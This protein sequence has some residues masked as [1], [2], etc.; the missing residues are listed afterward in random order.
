MDHL[1]SHLSKS[2]KFG[3]I[4]KRLIEFPLQTCPTSG[5]DDDV[6][7]LRWLDLICVL[8]EQW[9]SFTDAVN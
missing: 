4:M 7:C 2:S 6:E 5:N 1:L 3:K 8:R 9:D